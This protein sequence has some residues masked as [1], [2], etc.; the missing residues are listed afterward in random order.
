M[1]WYRNRINSA[2]RVNQR[3][4]YNPKKD[5]GGVILRIQ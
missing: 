5:F 2:S 3:N 1:S 4:R